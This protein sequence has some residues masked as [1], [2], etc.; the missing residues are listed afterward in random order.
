[1]DLC[2]FHISYLPRTFEGFA[3]NGILIPVN[4]GEG[5]IDSFTEA[6]IAFN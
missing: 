1:M 6:F 3:T 2:M 4:L 5:T